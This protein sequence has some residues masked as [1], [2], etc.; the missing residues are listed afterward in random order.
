VKK[1]S[2]ST[3]KTNHGK[4]HGNQNPFVSANSMRLFEPKMTKYK[5]PLFAPMV[6]VLLNLENPE[7]SSLPPV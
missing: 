5:I 1:N 3:A 4:K 2:N 6:N 7:K